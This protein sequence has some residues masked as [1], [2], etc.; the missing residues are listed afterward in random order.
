MVD[1]VRHP[2][3]RTVVKAGLWTAPAVAVVN[4]TSMSA[5]HAS[6]PTSNCTTT[7]YTSHAFVVYFVNGIYY[8][9][10]FEAGNTPPPSGTALDVTGIN[11]EFDGAWLSLVAPYAGHKVI[12]ASGVGLD[13]EQTEWNLLRGAIVANTYLDATGVGV[14]FLG[15]NSEYN[16]PAARL[17]GVFAKDGS[18]G[19]TG[20]AGNKSP[21]YPYQV[22]PVPENISGQYLISKC[23]SK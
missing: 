3:R 5:A 4:L 17:D 11:K 14:A 9:F 16:G 2:T 18:Y 20:L 1:T 12:S 13:A 22:Q 8:A 21:V 23:A 6:A 7:T 19:G 15:L 10:K